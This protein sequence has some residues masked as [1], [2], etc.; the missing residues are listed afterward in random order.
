MEFF[1]NTTSGGVVIYG[2]NTFES[3]S[4]P[5]PNRINILVSTTIPNVIDVKGIT[6]DT[7]QNNLSDFHVVKSLKEALL[8]A[9]EYS[10]RTTFV[11][12]GK[13]LIEE[14]VKLPECE[15]IYWNVFSGNY[16]SD[17][18]LSP[19]GLGL[20]KSESEYWIFEFKLVNSKTQSSDTETLSYSQYNRIVKTDESQYMDLIKEILATG[21]RRDNRTG[22]HTLSLFGKHTL[23]FNLQDGFP[24]FTSKYVS[25]DSVVKE[26][27]WMLKGQTDSKILEDQKVNIWKGNTSKEF[28]KKCGLDLPEGEIGKGYGHQWRNFGG[29]HPFIDSTYV[30]KRRCG[31]GWNGLVTLGNGS[32]KVYEDTKVYVSTKCKYEN[33]RCE[34]YPN[35]GRASCSCELL[36]PKFSPAFESAMI[37][38]SSTTHYPQNHT[39]PTSR[40]GESIS[41]LFI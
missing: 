29:T 35:E 11:I 2:R 36:K 27:L 17:I 33:V 20:I 24:L 21:E 6:Q 7:K 4:K 23:E 34:I 16:E 8:K 25:F 5:L 38:T 32:S 9:K 13:S 18:K 10:K 14:A 41:H 28:I 37:N 15:R 1:K 39:K 30:L 26:L 3:L 12:G 40:Y 31:C 19:V 22:T